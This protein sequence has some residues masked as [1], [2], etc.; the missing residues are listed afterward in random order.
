MCL[1]PDKYYGK[2]RECKSL[3]DTLNNKHTNVHLHFN[4]PS[5]SN[6]VLQCCLINIVKVNS[7]IQLRQFSSQILL[8]KNHIRQTSVKPRFTDDLAVFFFK[9]YCLSQTVNL[10][11]VAQYVLKLFFF[12]ENFRH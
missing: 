12:F 1:C 7:K 6:F 5:I 2:T 4:R 8:M 9:D 11:T 3:L 10:K